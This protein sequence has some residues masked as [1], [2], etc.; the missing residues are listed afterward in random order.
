MAIIAARGN[1]E[2]T[3]ATPADALNDGTPT[4]NEIPDAVYEVLP[5]RA[6]H[7]ATPRAPIAA[8]ETRFPARNDHPPAVKDERLTSHR[9]AATVADF[10]DAVEEFV[11]AVSW[12]PDALKKLMA[13]VNE[14]QDAE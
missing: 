5:T 7:F 13:A 11:D 6:R 14:M 3:A 4:S 10:V 9:F 2:P 8:A 1:R 12:F